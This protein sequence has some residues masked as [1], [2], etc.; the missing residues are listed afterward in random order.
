MAPK[1]K[2]KKNKI[3]CWDKFVIQSDCSGTIEAKA[4]VK[5]KK[6]IPYLIQQSF[7]FFQAEKELENPLQ[8]EYKESSS[9]H[10]FVKMIKKS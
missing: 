1:T 3:I 10:L 4:P 9:Y 5:R 6:N 2:V 7:P 8:I